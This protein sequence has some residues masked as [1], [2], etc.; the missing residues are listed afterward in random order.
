MAPEDQTENEG[1]QEQQGEGQAKSTGG[2]KKILIL[3][4]AGLV[5]LLAAFL[6]VVGVIAP[7]LSGQTQTEPGE[8]P[9]EPAAQEATASYDE[10]TIIVN[11][12]GS[13]AERYLKVTM[14]LAVADRP[15]VLNLE[16]HG[17]RLRNDLIDILSTKTV[18]DILKPEGK[19]ILRDEIT[20]A[21]NATLG[22]PKVIDV[23]FTEF[24][25]Q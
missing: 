16:R 1:Q 15:A 6:L 18:D 22:E 19:E 2:I 4:G 23:Y 20:D 11:L 25:I 7:A 12:A 14:S 24:V 9:V 13:N 10:Q 21:A 3:G 17:A 8:E 5:I